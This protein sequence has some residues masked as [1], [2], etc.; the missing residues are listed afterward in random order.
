[1]NSELSF[2]KAMERLEE[3]VNQLESGNLSLEQAIEIYNEGVKLS[4][5]CDA[6]LNEA[7]GKIMKISYE[8]NTYK[9]IEISKEVKE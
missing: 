2:E 5:Y 6:K 7:E 1:M 8:N 4:L 3:I 9:E